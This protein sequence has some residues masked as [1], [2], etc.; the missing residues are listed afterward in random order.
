MSN[1]YTTTS[2]AT[3]TNT[4]INHPNLTTDPNLT[5]LVELD[6]YLNNISDTYL[7]DLDEL[8]ECSESYIVKL[9]LTHNI[10]HSWYE[11]F[12]ANSSKL[13]DLMENID[14]ERETKTIYPPENLVFKVFESDIAD[15]K[16]V[17]LGQDPYI[18]KNQAMG[19][20]F[21]VPQTTPIAPSLW[22]IFKEL[23]S[24]FPERNYNFVHGDL[25]KWA[26]NGVFLLNSALTVIEKKSNSQQSMWSWFTNLVIEYIS[27]KRSGI[28][29]LLLGRNAIDKHIYVDKTRNKIAC[30]THPSPLSAYNGFFGSDIFK[31][32]E[33][34]LGEEFDWSN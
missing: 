4:V 5:K 30:G 20:S 2:T 9:L 17:L 1:I 11:L 14:S 28:V 21:S 8:N 12:L 25:T 22:N 3:N 10:H 18:S 6:D 31:K 29:Y 23:K 34:K 16:I 7:D 26:S 19:L 24:E 32:V 33:E 13:A 27:S 15:I